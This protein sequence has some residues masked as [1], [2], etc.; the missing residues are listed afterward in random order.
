MNISTDRIFRV[1]L[2]VVCVGFWVTALP[3]FARGIVNPAVTRDV[4]TAGAMSMAALLHTLSLVLLAS[5]VERPVR[6]WL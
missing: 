5:I 4:V 1:L 6:P 3:A 2:L